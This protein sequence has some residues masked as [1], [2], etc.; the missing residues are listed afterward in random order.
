M[1][2]QTAT[3]TAPEETKQQHTRFSHGTMCWTELMSKDV[4][5][6][7]TFYSELFGW[8]IA[9]SNVAGMTYSEIVVGDQHVGGM[10]Q[11]TPECGDGPSHWMSY[12]AVDDVD[13][14]A[15]QVTKLGGSICVPPTDIPTVGR[16]CV[17]TDPTGATL[18]MI[19]MN[20]TGS[21]TDA[22]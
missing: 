6:A 18:S 15:K 19:T 7:K 11:M 12:V 9:E 21:Q 10:F 2:E 16:F 17:I 3:A 13:A 14:S 1:S 22:S 8:K 5:K 4:E 20:C